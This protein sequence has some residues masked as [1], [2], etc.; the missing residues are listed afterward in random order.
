VLTGVLGGVALLAAGLAFLPPLA[1][2]VLLLF[3]LLGGLGI[4]NGAVFQLVPQRFP[5]KVGA[6][7]GLVGAAGGVG[8]FLLPFGLGAMKQ[9]TGTF[10]AGFFVYA[11]VGAAAMWAIARRQRAWRST[12]QLAVAI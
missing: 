5:T 4:A 6:L 7:T 1:P 12:W 10:S 11:A 8:G 9:A 2:T 3:L